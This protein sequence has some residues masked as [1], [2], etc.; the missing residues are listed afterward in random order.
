MEG[1]EGEGE[2]WHMCN[3][4]YTILNISMLVIYCYCYCKNERSESCYKSS[5]N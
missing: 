2:G 5:R 1:L 4:A 3:M